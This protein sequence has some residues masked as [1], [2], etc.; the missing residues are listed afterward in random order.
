MRGLL[1]VG[2]DLLDL[3]DAAEDCG[4]LDEAGL[5]AMGDDLGEGRLS[6]A[7]RSPE[8]HRGGIIVFDGDTERL[9]GCK[10]V[11]LADVLLERV[12]PHAFSQWRL[13]GLA[14]G[15]AIGDVSKRLIGVLLLDD[16]EAAPGCVP[17]ARFL[18][19]VRPLVVARLRRVEAIRRLQR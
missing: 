10:Q 3:L 2:H 15:A 1:G 5:G 13:A 16:A 12:R 17:T 18:R 4:E 14:R 8:D 6:G 11:F 7:G 19:M 9:S